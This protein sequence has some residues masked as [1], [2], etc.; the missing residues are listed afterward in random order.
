MK[1]VAGVTVVCLLF[2][3]GNVM[4][5][6]SFEWY[7]CVLRTDLGTI[8]FETDTMVVVYYKGQTIIYPHDHVYAFVSVADPPVWHMLGGWERDGNKVPGFTIKVYV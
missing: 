2:L 8:L 1:L 5:E 6:P 3:I 4:A 7:H